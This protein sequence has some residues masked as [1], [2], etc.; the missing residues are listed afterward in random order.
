MYPNI[1]PLQNDLSSECVQAMAQAL[2]DYNA[3]HSLANANQIDLGKPEALVSAVSSGLPDNVKVELQ[4]SLNVLDKS[5]EDI[6]SAVSAMQNAKDRLVSDTHKLATLPKPASPPDANQDADK[7]GETV[8]H[9]W[10]AV[11]SLLKFV[12]IIGSITS[13]LTQAI[14]GTDYVK[15]G[16]KDL[17]G[18]VDK[19]LAVLATMQSQTN[20]IYTRMRDAA[21]AD[22]RNENVELQRAATHFRNLVTALKSDV[23]LVDQLMEKYL[24]DRGSSNEKKTTMAV[25]AAVDKAGNSVANAKN[26]LNSGTLGP[27]TYM[28]WVNQL[29]PLGKLVG[30]GADTGQPG[31]VRG[32]YVTYE[33][34]GK[35]YAYGEPKSTMEELS[36]QLQ[37]VMLIYASSDAEQIRDK[38]AAAL[39]GSLHL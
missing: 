38:W 33:K 19:T 39:R 8:E 5:R 30:E 29:V 22:V 1:Q 32:S 26:L 25:Y 14:A 37:R 3:M 2:T 31:S 10:D 35:N 4:Q 20:A 18:E 15:D 6:R 16:I 36:F 21:A 13:D 24:K 28:A 11:N 12:P 9:I 7:I 34:N 27:N 23:S 17:F